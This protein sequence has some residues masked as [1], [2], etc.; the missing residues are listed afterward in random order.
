M[1]GTGEV[2]DTR[3]VFLDCPA[4]TA[5]RTEMEDRVAH[6]AV[7]QGMLP[8]DAEHYQEL[9]DDDRM[10]VLLGRRLDNAKVEAAVDLIVKM[11][12]SKVWSIRDVVRVALNSMLRRSD[13]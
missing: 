9:D 5:E 2:E 12:L 13:S 4:S 1:C 8:S 7:R 3:H 6:V 10:L 11:F